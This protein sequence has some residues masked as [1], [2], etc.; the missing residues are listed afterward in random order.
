MDP[1]RSADHRR[2]PRRQAQLHPGRPSRRWIGP[3]LAGR[4][5][6]GAHVGHEVES[7]GLRTAARGASTIE[8]PT[9][10][11]RATLS[12]HNRR[13]PV[14]ATDPRAAWRPW[15]DELD[16]AA[17]FRFCY[18]RRVANDATLA[19]AETSLWVAADG[20]TS[21]SARPRT[22]HRCCEPEARACGG[23]CG[24]PCLCRTGR[25]GDDTG[26]TTATDPSLAGGP[27]GQATMTGS[28]SASWS[29]PL[30]LDSAV[31]VHP[32]TGPGTLLR[33]GRER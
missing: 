1:N 31:Q 19:W 8:E 7:P 11:W 24:A 3:Q 26:I 10:S 2:A 20:S 6:G 21:R 15:P 22:W 29:D 30:S 33:L 13:F 14:A 28:L 32:R 17:G 16:L 27:C 12:R 4:R 23:D 5:P 9:S 25:T 18:P